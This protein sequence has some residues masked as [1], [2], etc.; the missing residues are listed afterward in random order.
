[1]DLSLAGSTFGFRSLSSKPLTLLNAQH[2][3]KTKEGYAL[4]LDIGQL[5]PA[6][7]LNMRKDALD[8]LVH[9]TQELITG[10]GARI[11]APS[12]ALAIL[13]RYTAA[14]GQ[15]DRLTSIAMTL[16]KWRMTHT[17]IKACFPLFRTDLRSDGRPASEHGGERGIVVNGA[18][19]GLPNCQPAI[20]RNDHSGRI[21]RLGEVDEGGDV[22]SLTRVDLQRGN[23]P[24]FVHDE[25][26]DDRRVTEIA[27]NESGPLGVDSLD[28]PRGE[29]VAVGEFCP[30]EEAEYVG[31]VE[32]ARFFGFLVLAATVEAHRFG[33]ED[34]PTH[35]F[36]DRGGETRVGVVA[37]RSSA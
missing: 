22:V 28:D 33:E 18:E 31:V 20:A 4:D 37:L 30:D 11:V 24:A 19:V 12:L 10:F 5:S 9:H 34:V 17:G 27:A 16:R 3:A 23:A 35:R 14:L 2:V 6:E 36:V 8:I 7:A 21:D 25:P 15:D 13:D 29:A 32:E 1:M 26:G